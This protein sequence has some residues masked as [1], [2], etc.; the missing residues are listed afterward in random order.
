MVL[1]MFYVFMFFFFE[2]DDFFVVFVFKD[3]GGDVGFVEEWGVDVE[4]FVFVDGEYFVDLDSRVGFGIWVV[5][6]D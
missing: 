2:D 4:V 3:G 6:N 5:V 1:F